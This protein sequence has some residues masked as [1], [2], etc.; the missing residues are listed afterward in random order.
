MRLRPALSPEAALRL[1]LSAS[2]PVLD[3]LFGKPDQVDGSVP[4][5]SPASYPPGYRGNRR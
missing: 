1:A 5:T 2:D 4:D 3:L